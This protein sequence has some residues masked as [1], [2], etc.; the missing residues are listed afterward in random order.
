MAETMI[1]D[2]VNDDEPCGCKVHELEMA[3]DWMALL[4]A[5]G[6]VYL[7]SRKPPGATGTVYAVKCRRYTDGCLVF[8]A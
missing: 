2:L 6:L 5:E 3:G 8:G 4:R 7:G 1:W